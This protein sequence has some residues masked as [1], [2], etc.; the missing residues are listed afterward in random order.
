MDGDGVFINPMIRESLSTL[1]TLKSL[2]EVC[3][4]LDPGDGRF[5]EEGNLLI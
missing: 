4:E 1:K 5:P 2:N 3:F